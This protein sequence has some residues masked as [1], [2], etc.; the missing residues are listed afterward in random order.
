MLCVPPPAPAKQILSWANKAY[1][2]V[3]IH[4][5]TLYLNNVSSSL[6][7]AAEKQLC[8][9]ESPAEWGNICAWQLQ[10][11]SSGRKVPAAGARAILAAQPLLS[12]LGGEFIPLCAQR[13]LSTLHGSLVPLRSPF[14]LARG[15]LP[16]SGTEDLF[17]AGRCLVLQ[18]VLRYLVIIGC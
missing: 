17:W 6:W 12:P 14:P 3:D 10:I 4:S 11:Y 5:H 1:E 2:L 7:R 13:D 9:G 18:Q 8:L 16:V 15:C